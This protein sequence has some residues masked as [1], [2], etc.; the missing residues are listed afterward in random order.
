MSSL[1]IYDLETKEH[2]ATII[3]AANTDCENFAMAEYGDEYG[4]TYS[5]AF[6]CNDGLIENAAAMAIE[7]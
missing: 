2:V 6:G 5:P 7:A 3:G 1:Y 4:W